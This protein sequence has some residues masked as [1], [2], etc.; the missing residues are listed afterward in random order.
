MSRGKDV[1]REKLSELLVAIPM[2]ATTVVARF[3]LVVEYAATPDTSDLE[4]ILDKCRERGAVIVADYHHH[5]P[6]RESLV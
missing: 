1:D 6:T 5:A 3:C 4:E 2:S